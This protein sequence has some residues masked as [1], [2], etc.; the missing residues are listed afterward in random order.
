MKNGKVKRKKIFPSSNGVFY[1]SEKDPREISILRALTQ[2]NIKSNA[3]V[4]RC[5]NETGFSRGTIRDD[6]KDLMRNK[7]IKYER[8]WEDPKEAKKYMLTQEG[9]EYLSTKKVALKFFALEPKQKNDYIECAGGSGPNLPPI[10]IAFLMAFNSE[11]RIK[12][13]KLWTKSEKDELFA[14]RL[15][16]LCS[17]FIYRIFNYALQDNP[18]PEHGPEHVDW[19]GILELLENWQKKV[20]D[21]IKAIQA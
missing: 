9:L 2:N 10:L 15:S 5:M 18:L 20:E 3:L 11:N 4:E 19:P 12:Y 8:D 16:G 1:F 17:F 21:K 13:G 14:K 6:I 7:Y